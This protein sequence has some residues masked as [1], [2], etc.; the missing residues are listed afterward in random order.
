MKKSIFALLLAGALILTACTAKNNT[1]GD[2]VPSNSDAVGVGDET[3]V[4]TVEIP[5]EY[6]VYNNAENGFSVAVPKAWEVTESADKAVITWIDRENSTEETL[7]NTSISVTYSP[8]VT[9][10]NLRDKAFTESWLDMA[11]VSYAEV[12]D[13]LKTEDFTD[14][15]LGNNH[16]MIYTCSYTMKNESDGEEVALSSTIAMTVIEGNWVAFTFIYPAES[17]ESRRQKE[18]VK[19]LQHTIL[20]TLISV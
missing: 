1:G 11:V 19:Q 20:S 5:E 16:F 2:D 18:N 17:V 6:I 8:A 4:P 15:A 10:E 13:N 9:Q 14:I 3:S 7:A 12:F